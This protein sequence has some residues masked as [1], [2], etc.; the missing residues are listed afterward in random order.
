[1]F[2]GQDNQIYSFFLQHLPVWFFLAY[3]SAVYNFGHFWLLSPDEIITWNQLSHIWIYKNENYA[4]PLPYFKGCY[5]ANNETDKSI[6]RLSSI[7]IWRWIFHK[8]VFI[9]VDET[10]RQFFES[11]KMWVLCFSWYFSLENMCHNEPKYAPEL[12]IHKLSIWR[13]KRMHIVQPTIDFIANCIFIRKSIWKN[14]HMFALMGSLDARNH[15]SCKFARCQCFNYA[16]HLNTNQFMK[17]EIGQM[18]RNSIII[19]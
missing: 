6:F 7:I 2:S 3:S 15:W 8:K 5:S 4:K 16:V 17:L 11:W 10:K 19:S 13:R 1:M 14:S 12:F 9:V 18:Q